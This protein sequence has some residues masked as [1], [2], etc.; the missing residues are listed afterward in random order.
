MSEITLNSLGSGRGNLVVTFT[1]TDPNDAVEYVVFILDSSNNIVATDSFSLEEANVTDNENGS[2]TIVWDHDAEDLSNGSVYSVQLGKNKDADLIMYPQPQVIT[3]RVYAVPDVPN[4]LVDHSGC[5][6]TLNWEKVPN[7]GSNVTAYNIYKAELNNTR[8]VLDGNWNVS[9]LDTSGTN[10]LV[11]YNNEADDLYVKVGS[12]YVKSPFGNLRRVVTVD[13]I[14]ES[15]QVGNNF[16][17]T[18]TGLVDA[19]GNPVS[20]IGGTLYDSDGVAFRDFSGNMISIEDDTDYVISQNG[21]QALADANQEAILYPGGSY[22]YSVSGDTSGQFVAQKY[23]VYNKIENVSYVQANNDGYVITNPNALDGAEPVLNL[24]NVDNDPYPGIISRLG[25]LYDLSGNQVFDLSGNSIDAVNMSIKRDA[26]GQP[27][28]TPLANCPLVGSVYQGLIANY[29]GDANALGYQIVKHQGDADFGFLVT[30]VNAAGESPAIGNVVMPYD[31]DEIGHAEQ[32]V[33]AS[34]DAP[35]GLVATTNIDMS[36]FTLTWTVPA[37]N[38]QYIKGYLLVVSDMSGNT[39]FGTIDL[40]EFY[41]LGDP[42]FVASLNKLPGNEVSLSIAF[43]GSASANSFDKSLA[44]YF[45]SP[46]ALISGANTGAGLTFARLQAINFSNIKNYSFKLIAVDQTIAKENTWATYQSNYFRNISQYSNSASI[47]PKLKPNQVS[48]VLATS[49][50][51]QVTLTITDDGQT[52]DTMP[53]LS[54]VITYTQNGQSVIVPCAGLTKTI[55]GLTN[56]TSYTFTVMAR[57]AKGLGPGLPVTSSGTTPYGPPTPPTLYLDGHDLHSVALAWTRPVNPG[58]VSITG[59]NIF[60]SHD[61]KQTWTRL[62]TGA[63]TV[64]ANVYYYNDSSLDP[65]GN[66]AN[67]GDLN[68]QP[69]YYYVVAVNSVGQSAPSN[70]VNE[71]PS[72]TPGAPNL[73][74]IPGPNHVTLRMSPDMSG[75]QINNGGDPL[76]SY[77]IFKGVAGTI[78]LITGAFTEYNPRIDGS[79]NPIMP[80]RTDVPIDGS[81]NAIFVD[82]DV[83]IGFAYLYKVVAV[84]RDGPGAWNKSP[85]F[86]AGGVYHVPETD[87]VGPADAPDRITTLLA[88]S[89]Y[90]NTASNNSVID[91]V[92]TPPNNYGAPVTSYTLQVSND[93]NNWKTYSVHSGSVSS[94]P[95]ITVSNGASNIITT[96]NSGNFMNNGVLTGADSLGYGYLYDASGIGVQQ[97]EHDGSGNIRMRVQVDPSGDLVN[98]YGISNPFVMGS[99]YSFRILSRNLFGESDESNVASATVSRQPGAPVDIGTGAT[100]GAINVGWGAPL[101]DGGS[102]ILSYML[103][104]SNGLIAIVPTGTYSYMVTNDSSGNALVNGTTYTFYVKAVNMNGVSVS[105]ATVSDHP[106]ARPGIPLNLSYV[107]QDKTITIQ[108]MPPANASQLPDPFTYDYMLKNSV[109]TI[110]SQNSVASNTPRIVTINGLTNGQTYTFYVRATDQARGVSGDYATITVVPSTT[111]YSVNPLSRSRDSNGNVTLTWM[112]PANDGGSPVIQYLIVWYDNQGATNYRILEAT[113]RSYQFQN[114]NTVH[115]AIFAVNTNGVS[116]M[117]NV[118]VV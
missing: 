46:P 41:L 71:Y 107:S 109:G 106:F 2:S 5:K 85:N 25:K 4:V 51:S 102:P 50:N 66:V 92:W 24:L 101:T 110:V 7:N 64:G 20:D 80:Y 62:G 14:R 26:N 40:Y 117:S 118:V 10:I 90:N 56:G 27:I 28:L 19:L 18:P 69:Y 44:G 30:A 34:P 47:M 49:G 65:S 58:G 75:N 48:S 77:T 84:N 1:D 39:V 81:G 104:D 73:D 43:N 13:Y 114:A 61:G 42:A 3:Q 91:L 16:I 33:Y 72:T 82:T 111:P 38:G 63:T 94:A 115:A 97:F 67:P 105:S 9:K 17:V 98:M 113:E 60:R 12:N 59:Y 36:G 57:N 89:P 55:K 96:D 68:Q 11:S 15:T 83:E 108:W 99:E 52:A 6:I 21:N 76:I 70:I 29:N 112:P 100:N 37:S 45:T 32:I 116:P 35:T 54:Y 88:H 93:G 74:I 95:S 8:I 23:G 79:G 53:I 86:P 103:Y 78:D 31:D 87:Y 22:Y